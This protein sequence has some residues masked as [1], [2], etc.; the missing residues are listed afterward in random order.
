MQLFHYILEKNKS[1]SGRILLVKQSSIIQAY[2]FY[3]FEYMYVVSDKYLITIYV[4]I[5]HWINIG[6]YH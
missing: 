5:Y 1:V 2:Q 6:R 3:S 4:N